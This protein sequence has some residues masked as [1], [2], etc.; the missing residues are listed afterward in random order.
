MSGSKDPTGRSQWHT[1][2]APVAGCT[3]VADT[4]RTQRFQ[5]YSASPA[6]RTLY[7]VCGTPRSSQEVLSET[8]C[9]ESVWQG[10]L[11][12]QGWLT[13]AAK[14]VAS[15]HAQSTWESYNKCMT[16]FLV[17][18]R[19]RNCDF[20]SVTDST[21]AEYV[22]HLGHCCCDQ[23]AYCVRSVLH[24]HRCRRPWASSDHCQQMSEN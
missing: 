22:C 8:V 14:Q 19:D 16:K 5:T 11:C 6:S 4:A 24:L 7:Q 1:A 15:C 23:K 13:R 10:R 17:F 21:V 18:L 2:G 9:L 12:K 3:M 20:S